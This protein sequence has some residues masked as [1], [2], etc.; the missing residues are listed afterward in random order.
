MIEVPSAALLV[1]ALAKEVDFF[2]LGTNDLVQYVLAADREDESVADYYQPLHPA[3]L[4]LI[5][6]V[7]DA[8]NSAGRELT[9]CGEMAGDPDY[10][11]LLLGLGLR[12]FSVAPGELLDVKNAHPQDQLGRGAA[13][14]VR[15][16]GAGL[17]GRDRSAGHPAATPRHRADRAGDQRQ[18]PRHGC[19]RR[20]AVPL[21]ARAE[22]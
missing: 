21:T 3:I 15:G 13:D 7:A 11:E 8:A 22:G 6:F 14:R 2:S 1:P 16:L 12:A 5:H 10:T 20:G 9:I 17:G 18:R 19:I 4:R